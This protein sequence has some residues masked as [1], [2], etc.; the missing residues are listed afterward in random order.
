VTPPI[1]IAICTLPDAFSLEGVFMALLVGASS[2]ILPPSLVA[3]GLFVLTFAV[4]NIIEK[5]RWD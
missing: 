2:T 1:G 4:L 3:I 5:G